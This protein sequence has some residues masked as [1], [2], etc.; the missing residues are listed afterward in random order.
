VRDGESVERAVSLLAR[1]LTSPVLTNV[2]LRADG[3]R[4]SQLLPSG[5]VDLFAGQD[6]VLLAR[7]DGD[8]AATLRLEGESADGPVTWTTRA[9]F[10]ERDRANPFVARLWAAQRVGWLAAEKR[11]NGATAELDGEIRSLGEKYGIP[12]EFSSYLV[13]EPGMPVAGDQSRRLRDGMRLD[14]V[15]TTGTGAVATAPLRKGERHAAADAATAHAAAAP[16]APPPATLTANEARFEA[17]RTAAAQRESKSL[18]TLDSL[19]AGGAGTQRRVGERLLALANGVWTDARYTTALRT[20]RVKPYSLAYFQLMQRIDALPP[21]FAVGDRLIVAGRAVAIA[22]AA[23]GAESLAPHE[24]ERLV[25]D[26]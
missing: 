25:R 4:L 7:Y 5:A 10:P 18:A 15:V 2:R 14:A 24:L 19:S 6:L 11:R 8:G 1:R 23:D 9:R 13:V 16:Q 20:V 21:L 3:V 12:T 17:A 22:L 26:W